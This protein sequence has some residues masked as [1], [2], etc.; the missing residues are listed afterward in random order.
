[1]AGSPRFIVANAISVENHLFVAPCGLQRTGSR[2]YRH[3]HSQSRFSAIFRYFFCLSIPITLDTPKS[4]P[5]MSI[6]P[7]PAKQSSNTPFSGT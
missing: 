5:A 6:V 7:E 3:S 1:M 2:I 4:K